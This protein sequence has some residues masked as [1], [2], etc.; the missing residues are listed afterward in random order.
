MAY[1]LG[2]DLG[3]SSIKALIID[4]QGHII[5]IGQEDYNFDIPQMGYAEIDP[6]IW[7][8][9]GKK[10][11]RDA[12]A[13][14][15]VDPK[16]IKGIGFSGQMHGL[17][18][19]DQEQ[20]VVRKSILHVD[21]RC[22]K[23]VEQTK[24]KIGLE[25]F[26][27][28]TCN[29]PAAGFMFMSLLW[30]KENEP[31][32]YAKIDKVMLPKDYFRMKLTGRV[33]TES[34]DASGSVAF[35]TSERHWAWDLIEELGLDKAMFPECREACDIAGELTEE[36][37]HSTGLA[38]GTPIVYGCSDTTV[39]SVGNGLIRPGD[40]IS[41]IGTASQIISCVNSPTYDPKLRTNTF[42]YAREDLW[43][44]FGASLNGGIAQKWLRDNIF[45]TQNYRELDDAA[46]AVQP[47]S[48]GLLFLPYLCGE[49]LPCLD[50]QAR[51]MFLG[52]TIK[53]TQ[54]HMIRAVME[55][56]IFALRDGL[57]IFGELG[58]S[59]NKVIASGGG[60]KSPL[61]LQ[62]QADIYGKDIY[63]TQS[64]EQA[65]FGA[66]ICAGV[67]VG[68]FASLEEACDQ[69]ISMSP[70]VTHPI[71]ENVKIYNEM[72]QIYTELYSRNKDLFHRL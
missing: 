71:P 2:I 45:H 68:L 16:E 3:T 34:G 9:A 60:T 28:I 64:K 57:E 27:K 5:G 35:H 1:L 39:Q 53:H 18:A 40:V 70:V 13:A 67:G 59:A 42:C 62:I 11:I 58:I 41:N 14:G 43:I 72:Y 61:L 51:G 44:V 66:A 25:R 19:V 65:S 52:L 38:Q 50:P 37:A 26:A 4:T 33:G 29:A 36:A 7:W 12:L 8:E 32:N 30:V 22:G 20:R 56:M 10:S 49:R 17:V 15:K 21:Q 46:A 47:G 54:A 48:E 69:L 23:Q 55:G 24:A 31:E 6:E 63:T